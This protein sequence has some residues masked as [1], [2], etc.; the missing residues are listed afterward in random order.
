MCFDA[1]GTLFR[2]AEPVHDT[3]ARLA[4]RHG[5]A[6]DPRDVAEGFRRA[7]SSAPPL[8]FPGAAKERLADLER[9]WWRRI[10]RHTFRVGGVVRVPP[11][12]CDALFRHYATPEAWYR[13]EDTLEA[14]GRLRDR[15]YRLGVISNFDSR[16][17]GILHG[18]GM[19]AL[20]DCVTVSSAAGDAKPGR[21]I[22][23][24]ALGALDV[25]AADALHVG[26]DP[27]AD[28]IGARAAGLE[29]VLID[30]PPGFARGPGTIAS[31][32]ELL[33]RL[34]RSAGTSA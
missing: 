11:D 24:Q 34:P 31:L 33:E 9:R 17:H 3:Y 12:L 14:L 23:E 1:A 5:L 10:V 27:V 18:L 19:S 21:R 4:A 2:L 13:Y 6:V 22:F 29:G 7:L 26:D 16:L 15:G 30:R 8:A 20:L 28:V 32:A 25:G